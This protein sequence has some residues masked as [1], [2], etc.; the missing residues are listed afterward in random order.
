MPLYEIVLRYPDR[1]EVRITDRDPRKDGVVRVGGLR[2]EIIAE[3]PGQSPGV[4][5]RY[6]ACPERDP[7]ERD[8][9]D[10]S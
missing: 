2:W 4:T 3:K 5:R 1:D 6:I 8:T 7:Q 10:P 9:T